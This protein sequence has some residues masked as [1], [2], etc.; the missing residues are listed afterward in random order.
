ME[1][2]GKTVVKN[3]CGM[4][5]QILMR[6]AYSML[7]IKVAEWSE[8]DIILNRQGQR[9]V[10]ILEGQ[11]SVAVALFFEGIVPVLYHVVHAARQFA[12]V[13]DRKRHCSPGYQW[14]VWKGRSGRT[15]LLRRRLKNTNFGRF[16]RIWQCVLFLLSRLRDPA[17]ACN[18]S[19]GRVAKYA[20]TLFVFFLFYILI[21]GILPVVLR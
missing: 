1:V 3:Q 10:P 16:R 13:L 15:F 12:N 17:W 6:R 8:D 19:D 18:H 5:R 7:D 9:P 2:R 14:G 21:H 4:I 11:G 20:P